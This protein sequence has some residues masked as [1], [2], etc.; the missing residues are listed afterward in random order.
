MSVRTQIE[1]REM[2]VKE[3]AY[4]FWRGE[5]GETNELIASYP[6]SFTIVETP[7]PEPEPET[8]YKPGY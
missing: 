4:Q 5:Y 2:T 8:E 6:V 3:G 1:A 7:E